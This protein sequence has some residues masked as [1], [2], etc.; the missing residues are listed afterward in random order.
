[1]K[2]EGLKTAGSRVN[3]FSLGVEESF[4]Y[5]EYLHCVS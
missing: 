2:E 1:M 4:P 5:M 3:Q